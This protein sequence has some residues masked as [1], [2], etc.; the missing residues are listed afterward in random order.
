MN[1]FTDVYCICSHF[2]G[3]CNLAN[4]VAGVRADHAAAE[5]FAVAVGCIRIIKQQ[6]GHAFIATVGNCP[7]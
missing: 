3:Q 5:A 2:N 4:H 7:A 6:F 1:G